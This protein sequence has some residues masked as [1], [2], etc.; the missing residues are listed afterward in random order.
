MN[1][2][3]SILLW[4][5]TRNYCEI[6]VTFFFFHFTTGYDICL[7]TPFK[8]HCGLFQRRQQQLQAFDPPTSSLSL[9]GLWNLHL[10]CL[11]F[12]VPCSVFPTCHWSE[13]VTNSTKSV[14][15]LDAPLLLTA[16]AALL[17]L[18]AASNQ[19][20]ERKGKDGAR[21]EGGAG[22]AGLRY[23]M[24]WMDASCLS[25]LSRRR[26]SHRV[27]INDQQVSLHYSVF[28]LHFTLCASARIANICLNLEEPLFESPTPNLPLPPYALWIQFSKTAGRPHFKMLLKSHR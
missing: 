26:R 12:S 14:G 19:L 1:S 18:C 10:L 3:Y 9:V 17:A 25:L 28:F 24:A 22:G 13:T 23:T 16:R 15:G 4:N 8:A 7:N 21:G 6:L 11:P 5:N 2:Q 27:S 20:R